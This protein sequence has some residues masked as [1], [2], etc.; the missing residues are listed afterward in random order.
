MHV[1][2]RGTQVPG[3]DPSV[4]CVWRSE[5][6]P[7]QLCSSTVWVTGLNESS[8]LEAST[9]PADASLWSLNSPFISVFVLY[10]DVL[11]ETYVYT[12]SVCS[13]WRD[14]KRASDHLGM[15]L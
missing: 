6:L 10:T 2:G 14:E 1:W 4:A 12:P 3:H 5:V 13:T 11:P 7:G 15:E 9:L 8:D